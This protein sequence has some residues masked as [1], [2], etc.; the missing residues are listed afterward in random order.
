MAFL[1]K[2]E[3]SDLCGIP[4]NAL[5]VYVKRK[6]VV[7]SGEFVDDT[8]P[9]NKAFLKKKS[10]AKKRKSVA[11]DSKPKTESKKQNSNNLPKNPAPN[12]PVYKKDPPEPK[13][14]ITDPEPDST[15]LLEQEKLTLQNT[16]LER[17]NEIAQIKIEKL[18]GD[19]IPTDI[20]KNTF[21]QHFK[22]ITTSFHQGADNV[23]IKIAQ[24]YDL[25]RQEV[26]NYRGELI[27]IIND[28]VKDAVEESKKSIQ[29]IVNEYSQVKGVGERE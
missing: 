15:F 23:L 21:M 26:A 16:Q 8:L 17:A 22:S 12:L 7:L 10:V 14:Q 25:S 6:K 2:K 11:T 20:V 4:T 1:S 19:V 27:S 28:C 29:N 9:K 3:F 5:A 18:R 24:K 13:P